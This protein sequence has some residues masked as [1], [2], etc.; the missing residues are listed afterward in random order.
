MKNNFVI[1]CELK[2]AV[3]YIS[4]LFGYSIELG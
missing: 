2:I 3:S 4:F 1:K